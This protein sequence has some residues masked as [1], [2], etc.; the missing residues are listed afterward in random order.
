MTSYNRKLRDYDLEIDEEAL[1]KLIAP[2][3]DLERALDRLGVW[4]ERGS[5]ELLPQL[6]RAWHV[7]RVARVT[8]KVFGENVRLAGGSY[9]SGDKFKYL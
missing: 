3:D 5:R 7:M 8:E 9:R 6:E 2:V 4:D 1:A